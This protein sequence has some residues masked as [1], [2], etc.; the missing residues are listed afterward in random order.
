MILFF[1]ILCVVWE[2]AGFALAG[3][4]PPGK[5]LALFHGAQLLMQLEVGS[6]CFLLSSVCK[7][8]ADRSGAGI[9]GSL[10]CNGF[11]VQDCAGY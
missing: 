2:A 7:T 11:D 9:C 4:M 3:E 1:N 5:S 6:V 10:I 8:G